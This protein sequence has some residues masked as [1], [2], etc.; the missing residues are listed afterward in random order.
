MRRRPVAARCVRPADPARRGPAGEASSGGAMVDGLSL[1]S[2]QRDATDHRWEE[3]GSSGA[4]IKRSAI[5]WRSHRHAMTSN[6]G[7][8]KYGRWELDNE[9]IQQA[10]SASCERSSTV[11]TSRCREMPPAGVGP[12][13]GMVYRHELKPPSAT[14]ASWSDHI[15]MWS[16]HDAWVTPCCFDDASSKQL[17]KSG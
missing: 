7:L 5:R 10:P 13:E 4:I 8:N 6:N 3:P 11:I 2:I 12:W 15:A 17:S 9:N 16:L 1:F 14:H